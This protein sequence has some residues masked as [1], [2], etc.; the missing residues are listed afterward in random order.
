MIPVWF[1]A[2][3]LHAQQQPKIRFE[4]GLFSTKWELGDKDVKQADI[5][6]HLQKTNNDAY[7]QWRR[8]DALETQ[9]LIWTILATGSVVGAL[10]VKEKAFKYGGF[11]GGV[12]FGSIALGTALA[13]D[14][15]RN[16]AV[17]IYNRFAG[18]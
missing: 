18:Y 4:E 8:A 5:A 6:A 14:S 17:T 7:Y 10:L 15:K 13:S 9:T 11:G 2:W 3:N 1:L 16:K 12:L